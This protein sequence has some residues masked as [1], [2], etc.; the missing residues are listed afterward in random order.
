MNSITNLI[1]IIVSAFALI[2][3]Q[4]IEPV[5]TAD[6]QLLYPIPEELRI[7]QYELKDGWLI[8]EGEAI[9]IHLEKFPGALQNR[10]GSL[11]GPIG[12]LA[13]GCAYW[14]PGDPVPTIVV[15]RG[16]SDYT[17]RHQ[18]AHA[19]AMLRGY[20][21]STLTNHWGTPKPTK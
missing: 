15:H 21:P 14:M 3:C 16:A 2:G 11:G 10:C 19:L 1:G 17:I 18:A 5:I 4:V 6:V 8:V 7:E 9:A 12:Y 20:G 13:I